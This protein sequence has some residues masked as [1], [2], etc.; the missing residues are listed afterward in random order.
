MDDVFLREESLQSQA[1]RDFMLKHFKYGLDPPPQTFDRGT[2]TSDNMI[3]MKLGRM[4][5]AEKFQLEMQQLT[6]ETMTAIKIENSL[7]CQRNIELT[8]E[9]EESLKH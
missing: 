6:K 3:S 4:S 1:A 2:I 7:L 5:K 9:L 8:Y